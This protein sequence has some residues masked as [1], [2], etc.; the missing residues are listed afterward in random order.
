M[1][2]IYISV[3]E[4]QLNKIKLRGYKQPFL[5]FKYNKNAKQTQIHDLLLILF[6][7]NMYS[8]SLRGQY[9]GLTYFIFL[10]IKR[11]GGFHPGSPTVCWSLF[12]LFIY[13]ILLRPLLIK[14]S[15]N[16]YKLTHMP[17]PG[18]KLRGPSKGQSPNHCTV[19][20]IRQFVWEFMLSWI[21]KTE[22]KN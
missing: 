19:V 1:L 13:F 2:L 16:I 3:L 5:K 22:K 18:V 4:I 7:P 10:I 20:P 14:G 12:I 17:I 8:W 6:Y 15:I 9:C 11:K 21:G